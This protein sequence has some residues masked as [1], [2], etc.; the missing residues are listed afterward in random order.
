MALKDILLHLDGTAEA[1][2]RLDVAIGLA[3]AHGAHLVGLHAVEVLVPPGMVGDGGGAAIAMLMQQLHQDAEAAARTKKAAFEE[4]LRREAMTG[5]W[6]QASFSVAETM[7]L[8]ARYADLTV[9]GQPNPDSGHGAAA[10]AVLESVLFDSGRPLLMVPYAGRPAPIGR[11]ALVAWN[12]SREAARAVADALPLLATC[13]EV[14]VLAVNP[15]S[16]IGGDG[17]TPAADMALHLARHGVNATAAHAVASGIGEADVLLNAAADKGVDLLVMG[18]YGHSRL[19][20]LI[21]GGVTRGILSRMTV[22]VLL[23]H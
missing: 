12:A 17:E 8:H 4:R 18:G 16:G 2:I 6:R 14:T 5:E 15:R 7:A 23:A 11:R 19:R 10:T 13:E 21:L 22:P 20:Q 3:R 9:L 1:E